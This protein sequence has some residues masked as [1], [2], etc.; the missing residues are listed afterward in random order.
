MVGTRVAVRLHNLSAIYTL[1]LKEA[2]R[3]DLSDPKLW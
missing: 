3:G 1:E 2:L